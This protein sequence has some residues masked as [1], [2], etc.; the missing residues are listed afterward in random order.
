[1]DRPM[2]WVDGQ[3]E[4]A[5]PRQQLAAGKCSSGV[6]LMP[7]PLQQQQQQQEQQQQHWQP[8]PGAAWQEAIGEKPMTA[9]LCSGPP[10]RRSYAAVVAAHPSAAAPRQHAQAPRVRR[11]QSRGEQPRRG[12][13]KDAARQQRRG[14]SSNNG[15]S[16]SIGTLAAP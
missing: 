9:V 7:T 1:M 5:T 14:L 4:Q 12:W 13:A 10:E 6:P 8:P 3:E 15:G 16:A 2:S 11:L